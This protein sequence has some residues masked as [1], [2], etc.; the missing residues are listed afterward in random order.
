MALRAEDNLPVFQSDHHGYPLDRDDH[1]DC[2]DH[3]EADGD[4]DNVSV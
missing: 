2:D 4:D 1:L 3:D